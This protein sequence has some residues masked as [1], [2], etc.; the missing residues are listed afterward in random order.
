VQAN[1][2]GGLLVSLTVGIP[3]DPSSVIGSSTQ[4][5]A[6]TNGGV[7]L[8]ISIIPGVAPGRKH[9]E[10]HCS[11]SIINKDETLLSRIRD[12][13]NLRIESL[14]GARALV[15]IILNTLF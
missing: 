10:R 4:I 1:P 11:D 14:Q 8:L 15:L 7:T 2:N 3:V 13:V 6:A 9:L 5:S 12:K